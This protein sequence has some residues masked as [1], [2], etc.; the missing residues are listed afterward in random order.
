M[1][2]THA[3][4]KRA[5]F[6]IG[7]LGLTLAGQPAVTTAS[8]Q[9]GGQPSQAA[10]NPPAVVGI[11]EKHIA[12]LGGREKLASI[13]SVEQYTESEVFG[14]T[15]KGYR[16]EDREKH[17]YYSRNETS[18][19]IVESGFDGTRVW[20]KAS[21]FQG[22]LQDSD[23]QVKAARQRQPTLAEYQTSHQV[24]RQ[25]PDETVNGITCLVLETSET[26]PLGRTVSIK[27]YFDA[28]TYL[29]KQQIEGN[30][31]KQTTAWDDYR[32]V[33]GRPVAFQTT[34]TNPQITIKTK[35]TGVKYNV[36]LDPQKFIYA[37]PAAKTEP[38]AN[39][40]PAWASHPA[41]TAATS[42]TGVLTEAVRDETFELVWKTINESHWDATF[43]G[44][45]WK[46]VHDRYQPLV[47][48]ETNEKAFHEMLHKMVGELHHS[49]VRVLPPD[50]VQGVGTHG[51]RPKMGNV[52][53][54]LRW[55]KQQL[56]VVAVEPESPAAKAGFKPGFVVT[57]IN[58]KTPPEAYAEYVAKHPGIRL[59]K[60]FEYVRAANS[61]LSGELAAK[62]TIELLDGADQ[63]QS[64]ELSRQETPLQRPVKFLVK[65]LTPEVGY[66]KFNLFFGD[67]FDQFKRAVEEFK[68]TKALIIDV[69]GNPGGAGQLSTSIAALLNESDGSLGKSQYRFQTQDYLYTGTGKNAYQG[70]ILI[71]VDELSASTAEV[72][73]AGLQEN[74]RVQVLGTPTAGAVL[75]SLM[76]PLPTGG[77]L[78]YVVANFKTPQGTRL[79]GTGVKPNLEVHLQRKSLLAGTDDVLQ[80]ALLVANQK[81]AETVVKQ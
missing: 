68:D 75:P 29:L 25:L 32:Q 33:E 47:K 67:V 26:D 8:A 36:P 60:E 77:A 79:E 41:P 51:E 50:Q 5:L 37:G 73:T 61:L 27:Y 55:L 46:A 56:V 14:S 62:V 72:F 7:L 53:L 80:Q 54:D 76:L 38:A 59:S 1:T 58:G 31:I 18:A 52:G 44:V 10:E 40:Q 15:Q 22:Y 35:L 21:F 43:G 11:L 74:G 57:K 49:H 70:K 81:K 19:G 23:P 3:M 42:A 4:M 17:R 16:L 71:L 2:V 64:V 20:R 63:P 6:L 65:R 24:F 66:V 48:Q 9:P 45:D 39:A 78:Q 28:K 69:R 34:I 30:E 12:A 13:K